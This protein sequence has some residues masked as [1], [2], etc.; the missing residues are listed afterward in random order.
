MCGEFQ[1]VEIEKAPEVYHT[2]GSEIE[3]FIFK[4][5]GQTQVVWTI[6]FYECTISGD[7]SIEQAKRM[8]DS[9]KKG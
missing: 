5:V 8:V 2:D 9:I 6:G 1:K 4:N 7:M 3:Y